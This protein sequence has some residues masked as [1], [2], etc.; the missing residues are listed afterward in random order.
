[1]SG[2]TSKVKLE[3]EQRFAKEHPIVET[4]LGGLLYP[5]QITAVTNN[6]ISLKK[7]AVSVCGD[8][9]GAGKTYI[10]LGCAKYLDMQVFI[11]STKTGLANFIAIFDTIGVK[12]IGLANYELIKKGKYYPDATSYM[13]R[14]KEVCPY[15]EIQYKKVINKFDN[16]T[17]RNT[18]GDVIWKMPENT[19]IIIDE[20]HKAKNGVNRV[21][22]SMTS[23]LITSIRPYISLDKRIFAT[24][25]SASITDRNDCSDTLLYMLGLLRDCSTVAYNSLIKKLPLGNPM[26]ALSAI[27]FPYMGSNTGYTD[28]AE[29]YNTNTIRM[30]PVAVNNEDLNSINEY[31]QQLISNQESE[32]L[33]I[34]QLVQLWGKIELIKVKYIVS[35]VVENVKSGYSVIVFTNFNASLEYL[36]TI[37]S[38]KITIG[39]ISGSTPEAARQ[40]MVNDFQSN[41]LKALVVNIKIGGTSMNFHD[42]IGN[43]PRVTYITPTMS[44]IDFY[45]VLGRA[46]RVMAKSPIV[47]NIVTAVDEKGAFSWDKQIT[48]IMLS[49]IDRIN[50]VHGTD[51][52]NIE[53]TEDSDSDQELSQ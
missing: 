1:M 47:Q 29:W 39:V 27:L 42:T 32:K 24:M 2:S 19:L 17:I 4:E 45:Q 7:R 16:K 41:I 43:S 48:D 50:S 36:N 9:P 31:S 6:V 18:I 14:K 40:V 26:G 20:I 25:L 10:S 21:S 8:I 28:L 37:L 46:N 3:W 33:N 34:G 12:P 11:I 30:Y 22:S 15:L 49:G 5:Y 52:I 35:S 23:E 13:N 53:N 38:E 51:K 44:S